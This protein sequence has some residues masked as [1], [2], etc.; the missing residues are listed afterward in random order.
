MPTSFDSVIDL[1][2]ITVNDY[3]LGKLLNQ[4]QENFQTYCDGFLI[5]AIPQ[6]YLCKQSLSY[7][8]EARQFVADLTM[9][10]QSILADFWVIQW[11]LKETQDAAQIANKLQVSS[12]FTM[13]SPA[14]NLKEKSSYLDTMR[15]K[16]Y[17]K[18]NFYLTQDFDSIPHINEW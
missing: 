7:D 9:F 8:L 12:S 10:E 15:E 4:S 14:Q 16:V 2:L 6:F 1:A 11:F 5:A 17:Q 13:H 3:K 18:I